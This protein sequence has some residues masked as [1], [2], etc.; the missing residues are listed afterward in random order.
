MLRL[1]RWFAVAAVLFIPLSAGAQ[2]YCPAVALY[3]P[4]PAVSFYTPAVS[5]SAAVTSYSVPGYGYA[6]SSGYGGSGYASS[7]GGYGGYGGYGY[8]GYNPGGLGGPWSGL[9]VRPGLGLG[10]FGLRR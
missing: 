8:R 9:G 4:A 7:Y 2:D 6:P 1:S 3:T 10:G 5:Y